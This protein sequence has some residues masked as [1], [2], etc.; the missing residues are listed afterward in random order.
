MIAMLIPLFLQ[1]RLL[2][3][4]DI[5]L[6]AVMIYAIYN[7][8]KGTAA[9]NILLGII[10][11]FLVWRLVRILEMDLLAEILGAFISV[12]FIALIIVFQPEIRKFLL[13]LGTSA[14]NRKKGNR[15]L[16]WKIK[17]ANKNLTDIDPIVQAC[18]HMANSRTGALIVMSRI[19]ELEDYVNSG[20]LI[21]ARISDQLLEN[22]FFKNA[23]LHDG[24]VIIRNNTIVAA[25]CILPV[26]N[27]DG[28]PGHVG[29]RHRAAVGI[30]EKSD[31]VAIVVSEQTGKISWCE[32]GELQLNIPPSKLKVMLEEV[33]G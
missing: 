14:F 20:E 23:P 28:L 4:V 11:V 26:S 8:V 24:A 33:F 3:I 25:S 15:F 16:F 7:L 21:N 6:V 22:I 18:F 19:N 27:N 1:I 13:L 5:V 31:A 12:G 32:A 10:A 30:T 2:D 9:I 29:L 17:V